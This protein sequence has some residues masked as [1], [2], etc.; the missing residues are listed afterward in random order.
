MDKKEWE[1]RLNGL[2]NKVEEWINPNKIS[3]KTV[4]IIE[5]F[6]DEKIAFYLEL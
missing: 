4:E 1:M 3:N 6:Y 5:L 2:K